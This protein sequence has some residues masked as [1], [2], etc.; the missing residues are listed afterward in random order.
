MALREE[1]ES[2]GNWLFR[3][4]SYLPLLMIGIILLGLADFK[5]ASSSELVD[6]LWDGVCILTS[7]FGIGIRA[8]TVGYT[9]IG[10]SGRNTRMQRA[11]SLNR[12]GLYSLVRNPLYVGNYFAGLG[13]AMFPQHWWLAVIYTLGFWL[14]YERIIFAEEAYL[15]EK[16]GAEFTEWAARTPVFIPRLRGWVRPELPFSFL[17]VLRREYNGLFGVVVLLCTL[18]LVGHLIAQGKLHFDLPWMIFLGCA[19]LMWVVLRTLKKTTTLLNVAG[20]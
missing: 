2:S 10:T 16:F 13:L 8:F 7:L 3:W 19:C 15:R 6:D 20:R 18:E 12:T 1:F 17:N 5:L 11:D 14:Y 9:P 4:R